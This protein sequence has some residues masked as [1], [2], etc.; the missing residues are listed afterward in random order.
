MQL[1]TYIGKAISAKRIEKNQTL[2]GLSSR[3]FISYG[4]L[5]E[6]ERGIKAPSSDIINH[7]CN[8]L[9][10]TVLDLMID[11][12]LLMQKDSSSDLDLNLTIAKELLNGNFATVNNPL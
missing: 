7:I 3:A 8:G 2:R 4:Y 10:I 5:S 6:V 11:V 1:H 9:K 12:V